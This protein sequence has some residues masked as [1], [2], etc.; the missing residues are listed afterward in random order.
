MTP[1][2]QI[3]IP[4]DKAAIREL[5]LAH[6]ENSPSRNCSESSLRPASATTMSNSSSRRNLRELLFDMVLCL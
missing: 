3:A 6:S 2:G 4:L 5:F 1:D